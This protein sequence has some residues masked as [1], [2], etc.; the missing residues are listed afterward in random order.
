MASKAFRVDNNKVVSNNNSRTN[1]T[2]RNLSRTSTHISNIK[3]IKKPTF[4]TPNAKKTFNYLWLAFIKVSISQHFDLKSH[5]QN[6][7]NALG[8][9]IDKLFSLLNLDF[10]TPPNDLKNSDFGQ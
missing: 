2:V 10:D 4:L 9:I 8:Y 5:I 7:T 6:E 3:A 1:E